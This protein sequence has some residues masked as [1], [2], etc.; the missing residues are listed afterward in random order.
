M[1]KFHSPLILVCKPSDSVSW[2]LEPASCS[3]R[4]KRPLSVPLGTTDLCLCSCVWPLLSH[5]SPSEPTLAL[6]VRKDPGNSAKG[7][8]AFRCYADPRWD[9]SSA[10]G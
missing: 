8:G 7:S 9:S 5:L 1:Q 2:R 3:E 10:T 4:R 6:V